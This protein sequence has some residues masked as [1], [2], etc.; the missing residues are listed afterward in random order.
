MKQ[1]TNRASFTEY[2]KIYIVLGVTTE[3]YGNDSLD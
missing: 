2:V 3:E 1:P